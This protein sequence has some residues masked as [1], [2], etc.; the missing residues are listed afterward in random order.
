MADPSMDASE[1]RALAADMTKASTEVA[2][3][4]V[5]VILK[6]ATNIKNQMRSEAQSS[7]H[8]KGI[9]RSIDFDMHGA[10][11]FGVGIIEAEIGP[12]HGSGEAGNLAN[13]A[14]WGAVHGSS[15]SGGTVPDPQGALDAESPRFEQALADLI[16]NL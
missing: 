12:R 8:F 3:K 5:A 16:G 6:G 9:S 1:I 15:R 13:I 7:P 4:T 2:G 10:D 11:L 14:Y